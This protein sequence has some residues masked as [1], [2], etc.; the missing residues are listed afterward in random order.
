M[1]ETWGP[2]QVLKLSSYLL[3]S[4]HLRP[5]GQGCNILWMLWLLDQSLLLCQSSQSVWEKILN[6]KWERQWKRGGKKPTNPTSKKSYKTTATFFLWV[7]KQFF[8]F[9]R[10][11]NSS[12]TNE[13]FP[14][15]YMSHSPRQTT[16]ELNQRSIAERYL[17]NPQNTWKLNTFLNNTWAKE[18]ISRE[19]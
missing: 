12:K 9:Q 13:N 11:R 3:C 10:R 5:W 19:I 15:W 17:E 14:L 4:P 7:P 6:K 2:A 16:L 18:E 1:S 8:M